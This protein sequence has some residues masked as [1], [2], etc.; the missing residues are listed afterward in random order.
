MTGP[1]IVELESRSDKELVTVF[2]PS[3]PTPFTGYTITVPREEVIEVDLTVEEALR[4]TVSGGVLLPKRGDSAD[5]PN[6][7]PVSLARLAELG[8]LKAGRDRSGGD[9]GRGASSPEGRKSDAKGQ[10][11]ETAK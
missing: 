5:S 4:F 6:G 9:E 11:D 1:S 10:E 8:R 2:I 3:S 7:A